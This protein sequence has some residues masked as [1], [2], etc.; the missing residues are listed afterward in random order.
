M[1]A[2]LYLIRQHSPHSIDNNRY[3]RVR[4]PTNQ[5]VYASLSEDRGLFMRTGQ[6]GENR[7]CGFLNSVPQ[8][9][10]QL[11]KASVKQMEQS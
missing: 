8:I 7:N 11:G 5:P 6:N 1:A 4:S 2:L 3:S 9:H 10:K